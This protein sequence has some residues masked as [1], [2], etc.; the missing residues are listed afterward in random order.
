VSARAADFV[1]EAPAAEARFASLEAPLNDG[2]A[3]RAMEQDYED[4]IYH[5]VA[6][7]VRANEK[8]AIY[9]GP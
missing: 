7:T 6:V 5:E 4:W 9:A 3:I 2:K 1:T 8:L